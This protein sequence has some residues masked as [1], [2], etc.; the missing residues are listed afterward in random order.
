MTF[1]FTC[2]FPRVDRRVL[3][4]KAGMNSTVLFALNTALCSGENNLKDVLLLKNHL[5]NLSK[6]GEDY[7]GATDRQYILHSPPQTKF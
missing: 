1:T 2:S 6:H 3:K 7:H 5:V 4:P